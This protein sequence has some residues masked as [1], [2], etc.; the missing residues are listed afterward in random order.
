MSRR[1]VLASVLALLA[2]AVAGA[3][4][5]G[6]GW[7]QGGPAADRPAAFSTKTASTAPS[8]SAAAFL[9]RRSPGSGRHGL[10]D[11][12]PDADINF[13]IRLSELTKTRV[14]KQSSGEPNHL[15]VRLT[16][17]DLFNC[18]WLEMEDV[19]VMRLNDIEI[20]RLRQYLLK[21]GFYVDD[22]WGEWPGINGPRRSV[23][24]SIP[25]NTRS[26]I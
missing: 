14:S 18:L 22:F 17:D 6:Q 8:I 13:S 9:R 3:Q 7:G 2:A 21:G 19:G 10:V 20:T 25:E 4:G 1:F 24:F 12:L 16:D 15:V 26:S 5:L 11:R 23:V